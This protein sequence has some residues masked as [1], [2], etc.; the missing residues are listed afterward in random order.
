MAKT[1]CIISSLIAQPISCLKIFNYKQPKSYNSDIWILEP[2]KNKIAGFGVRT[3]V[4]GW[5]FI[6]PVKSICLFKTLFVLRCVPDFKINNDF[7]AYFARLILEQKHF[8][9]MPYRPKLLFLK[10]C[11]C[12]ELLA[13]RLFAGV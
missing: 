6:V 7:F 2:L 12:L 11:N 5:H 4:Q 3:F 8:E 10:Y 1:L 9:Q 13:T